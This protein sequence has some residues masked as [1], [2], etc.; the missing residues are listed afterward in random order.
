MSK[1]CVFCEFMKGIL[2][3]LWKF[4]YT[5]IGVLVLASAAIPILFGI[6][7]GIGYLSIEVCLW[8][9]PDNL[10]IDTYSTYGAI[11]LFLGI[12]VFCVVWLPFKIINETRK[13]I[14]EAYRNAKR[15]CN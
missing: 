12:L 9:T 2:L 7:V 1:K 13:A 5:T 10:T 3:G 4:T 14:I 6:L 11:T 15:K 8:D